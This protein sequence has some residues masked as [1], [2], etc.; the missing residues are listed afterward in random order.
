MLMFDYKC[1]HL[2]EFGGWYVP[3]NLKETRNSNLLVEIRIYYWICYSKN[4]LKS[5]KI[6]FSLKKMLRV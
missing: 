2:N 1:Q 4:I 6:T 5:S 3:L